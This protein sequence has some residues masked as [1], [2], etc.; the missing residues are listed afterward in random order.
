VDAYLA[1]VSKREVRQ[2]DDRPIPD[3]AIE[4]ILQAGR[5][6]GSSKNTQP[7]RFIVVTDRARLRELAR[8][9]SR[10][11]NL[12]GCAAAIAVGVLNP[13]LVLDA[14]RTAQNMMVAAWTLGIGTCPNTPMD[15][16][17]IARTLRLPDGA[18]VPTILSLGYPAPGQ[19]RPPRRARAQGVLARIR[20][21]PLGEIVHRETFR[22]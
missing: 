7:W 12:E 14:G 4:R 6:S 16:D 21:L 15:Q 19:P 3:E 18:K 9:V 22:G 2:Y 20:R 11:T 13:R 5:A 1:V 17:A 10:P 8:S